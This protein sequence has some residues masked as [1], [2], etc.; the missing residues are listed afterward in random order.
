MASSVRK[1]RIA[2]FRS[3]CSLKTEMMRVRCGL[4]TVMLFGPICWVAASIMTSPHAIT[5]AS[6][7]TAD[8]PMGL[9]QGVGC[10]SRDQLGAAAQSDYDGYALAYSNTAASI[11]V[12]DQTVMD[13]CGI[14]ASYS[15]YKCDTDD[16]YGAKCGCN[17][18]MVKSSY[19]FSVVFICATA[20]QSPLIL[21]A[22]DQSMWNRTR[23]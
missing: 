18:T 2:H 12:L 7:R 4:L 6:Y 13:A 11:S 8:S 16:G 9:L 5:C 23:V 21:L 20:R 17:G 22:D 1:V 10:G 14:T 15:V 3:A 19:N